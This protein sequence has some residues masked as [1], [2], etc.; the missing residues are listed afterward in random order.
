MIGRGRA[1]PQ[2]AV[3]P[4]VPAVP[5]TTTTTTTAAPAATFAPCGRFQFRCQN[6]EC[7][8]I[9]NACDGI[10]QCEDGS[11][12]T[13]SV[14]GAFYQFNY[15]LIPK[16]T[17][18]FI[19]PPFQCVRDQPTPIVSNNKKHSSQMEE[20]PLYRINPAVQPEHNSFASRPAAMP[21]FPGKLYEGSEGMNLGGG[22]GYMSGTI[23]KPPPLMR[24]REDP[25]PPSGRYYNNNQAQQQQQQ[26]NSIVPLQIQPQNQDNLNGM[27][28]NGGE[29]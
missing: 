18:K 9:Y 15:Y 16:I 2:T 29:C 25:V 20:P 17:F 1:P 3:A 10:V 12:E 13:P 24:N 27:M 19:N 23:E 7:I 8:A 11:D 28:Y 14:R 21:Q 26:R 5:A 6:G 4:I 22:G